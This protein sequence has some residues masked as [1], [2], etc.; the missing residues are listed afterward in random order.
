MAYELL[1][2]NEILFDPYS[3]NIV[4]DAK[5]TA[6]YNNPDYF[7][8]TVSSTNSLYDSLKERSGL[9][10]LYY[11]GEKIFEGQITSIEMDLDGNKDVKCSGP[12]SYLS[13]TLVRPYSTKNGEAETIAP[14]TVSGIFQWYIDQH[15]KHT[16]DPNKQFVVGVNQGSMLAAN[17]SFSRTSDSLPNTWN[18]IKNAILDDLGGFLFV[19]HKNSTKILNLYGDV[20]ETNAQIIDFG[21][22]IT[23]FSKKSDTS[24]QY[25]AIR[26]RGYTPK[27]PE[28]DQNKKMYPIT[29]SDLPD[30]VLDFDSDLVKKGDVIYSISAV[31]R[32]GYKEYAYSNNDIDDT[33]NLLKTAAIVLKTLISPAESITV[34]A[35]DLALYMD[36]Y[37]HLRVG[38]AVRIRSRLHDVDQYMMVNTITLDINN[39]ANTE[40][41]LGISYE[42]LTGQQS[43]YIRSLNAGIN[44]A[45]DTVN[46][47]DQA[48]KDT[49]II[50]DQANKKATSAIDTANSASSKADQA[51][52]TAN[53]ASL[54]ADQAQSMA[55]SVSS[56]ADQA[57]NTANAANQTAE[58]LKKQTAEIDKRVDAAQKAADSAA[59]DSAAATERVASVEQNLDGFKTTVSRTYA[60]NA[61]VDGIRVGA[62]NLL[63]DTQYMETSGTT[64]GKLNNSSFAVMKKINGGTLNARGGTVNNKSSV[65]GQWV[66]TDFT[67]GD[68]YTLSFYVDSDVSNT[69]ECY[70][71]GGAGYATVLTTACSGG[72]IARPDVYSDGKTTLTL[73]AAKKQRVWVTWTINKSGDTTIPK[74]VSIRGDSTVIGSKVYVYGVKLEKGSKPT[75]WSPAPEDLQ[76][77][78]DYATNSSVRDLAAS[79]SNLL[80]HVDPID[81]NVAYWINEGMSTFAVQK[82][83]D[84][85]G[86][87][88]VSYG[89]KCKCG[90]TTAP[91]TNR[92]YYDVK[93]FTHIKGQA[94][95]FSAWVKMSSGTAIIKAQISGGVD[96]VSVKATTTW[97]RIT[98]TYIA[99]TSGSL[100]LR[101]NGTSEWYMCAPYVA[102]C[103]EFITNCSYADQTA[104]SIALGVV[105]EYKGP[106]GSGL[107]TKSDITVATDNITSTVSKTYA[108]K[109]GVT[110]EIT[111]QITQNNDSLDVKFATKTENKKAQDTADMA[112]TTASDAQSRVGDLEPCIRMTSDGVRVGKQ[113]DGTYTG[114]SALVGTDGTFDVLDQS[115]NRLLEV[116]ADGVKFPESSDGHQL[117]LGYMPGN[118]TKNTLYIGDIITGQQEGGPKNRLGFTGDEVSLAGGDISISASD[119]QLSLYGHKGANLLVPD[120]GN[121]QVGGQYGTGDTTLTLRGSIVSIVG[122]R[123][124]V[125][126]RLIDSPIDVKKSQKWNDIELDA[127]CVN[128]VVT[129]NVIHNYGSAAI[130]GNAGDQCEIGYIAEGYRP[131]KLVGC[132]I[133]AYGNTRLILEINP[134]TGRVACFRDG[135]QNSWTYFSGNLSYII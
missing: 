37:K 43:S 55:D 74:Y 134:D 95:T 8:F 13:D 103:P 6:K 24:N 98:K 44:S 53:S 12:L 56:K 87:E 10:E 58:N 3:D 119:N 28:Y 85:I 11:N 67:L 49:A 33:T 81:L 84:Y 77:A 131:S 115:S 34:K 93:K 76:A 14:D 20:H 109:D 41:E 62:T 75:D 120:G 94:Y 130:I 106:D 127:K 15:N 7:D 91:L 61:K 72:T 102:S 90:N 48:T 79:G 39:P 45:L 25:T 64:N 68:Q 128:R 83:T 59:A 21:V 51:Q 50:A 47:L 97:T 69:I 71:Y 9:V 88:H 22:N 121:V 107:A 4:T 30:N 36:D 114:T 65:F 122:D 89:W 99:S 132:L 23:D 17:N 63:L 124:K 110:Q 35:I 101:C 19:E 92:I 108:T 111:S 105:Q 125:N 118:E 113:T 31:Q 80:E 32:Y 46:T 27:A 1:Y 123:I 18:E 133:G 135:N 116:G 38:Q 86:V 52:S 112:N 42:S 129:V 78:G 70:F 60:T 126:D 2:D 16:L 104:K 96:I 57:Q 40:Y 100:T 54:K 66:V 117:V 82:L 5:L 26:P 73:A 29:L